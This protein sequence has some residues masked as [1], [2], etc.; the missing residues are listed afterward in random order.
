MLLHTE[1]AVCLRFVPPLTA[2]RRPRTTLVTS[3]GR[4]Q[5][6]SWA[7]CNRLATIWACNQ[8]H[9][10]PVANQ[11]PPNHGTAKCTTVHSKHTS[12]LWDPSICKQLALSL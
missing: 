5:S 3:L 8:S 12:L 1:D 7:R 6:P 4:V 11:L 9:S 10:G 2:A